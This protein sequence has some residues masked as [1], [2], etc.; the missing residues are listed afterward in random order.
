MSGANTD[1]FLGEIKLLFGCLRDPYPLLQMF[2]LDVITKF[3]GE[4]SE[5]FPI[6]AG[7]DLRPDLQDPLVGRIV[8]AYDKASDD[9]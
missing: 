4:T 3:I 6:H 2:A 8:D 1:M 5:M 9:H 7:A